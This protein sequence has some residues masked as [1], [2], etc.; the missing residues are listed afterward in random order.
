[1]KKLTIKEIAE[2]TGVS[3]ATVS[4]VLNNTGRYS[5]ET[6]KKILD[7]VQEYDY[8]PNAV[9]KSLRTRRSKTIGV[10]VPDITNEFFAQIVLAIEKYCGPKGYSVFICNTDE[11]GEKELQ[12]IKELELKG[13]DGLIHLIGSDELFNVETNLP[14]VCIDRKP[15]AHNA[16]FITSDNFQGGYLAASELIEKG[17]KKI[18]LIRDYRVGH[19]TLERQKGFKAALKEKKIPFNEEEQ[20]LNV[21]VGI[22]QGKKA[23]QELIKN[24]NF[25]FDG[26]FATTDWLAFG[27]KL[28]LEENGIKIP[29][30]VKII[31]FDNINL[32]KYSSVSSIHQDKEAMGQK[33]AE[34]LINRIE[35]NIHTNDVIKL[36]V[37]LVSRSSTSV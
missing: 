22:E 9:A 16:A 24:G 5:E 2:L 29:E 20:V 8:R 15:M 4:K 34:N 32:A 12:Y 31:G 18:L 30:E 25:D 36:P 17:C 33:A 3:T 28:A 35:L 37:T 19:P 26:V 6:R 10:I 14:V 13:V 21:E 11:N 1:M 7:V 23:V 27:A